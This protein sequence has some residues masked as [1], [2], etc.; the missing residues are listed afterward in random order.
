MCCDIL[1]ALG[2][3]YVNRYREIV[4]AKNYVMKKNK[5]SLDDLV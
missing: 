1:F 2:V 3:V 4:K 5:I